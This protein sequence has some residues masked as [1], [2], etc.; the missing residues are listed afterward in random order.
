[1]CPELPRIRTS[2]LLLAALQPEQAS[3]LSRLADELVI[4][5]MTAALPSPY[6]REHA[7]AFIAEIPGHFAAGR[8]LS[9]GVHIKET[10]ELTGVISLRFATSH[11][12]AN[13]GY[14]TG[15][16]YRNKG[17]A[18][19]A[20]HGLLTYGFNNMNLNRIAGQCFSDNLASAKV[21]EKCGLL[22]EGCMK[23]AFMKNGVFKDMLLFG[24]LRTQ[25]EASEAAS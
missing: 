3:A 1:M 10:S 15:A 22:Y 17:Y 2:R 23:E 21:L 25:Y 16:D 24:L 19:E 7:Q 20:V 6:T 4:A 14:W 11:H 18:S 9:L 5:T 12:S 13:L 8:T